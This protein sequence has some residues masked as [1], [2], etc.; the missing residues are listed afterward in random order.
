MKRGRVYGA[1]GARMTGDQVT[2]SLTAKGLAMYAQQLDVS[3]VIAVLTPV[4]RSPSQGPQ[5]WQRI[6][7][8]RR[9]VISVP[10]MR[11][12]VRTCTPLAWWTACM[13]GNHLSLVPNCAGS[14]VASFAA[15]CSCVIVPPPWPGTLLSLIYS[16]PRTLDP[17]NMGFDP[18]AATDGCI[19]CHS[20][21]VAAQPIPRLRRTNHRVVA[22]F[23][24]AGGRPGATG[25]NWI[26]RVDGSIERFG[27][28]HSAW[29]P[30]A[31]LA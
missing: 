6:D 12:S 21:H 1:S 28:T 7:A 14:N 15:I 9:P 17:F 22:P 23:G 5:R 10:T 13:S 20:P 24:L 18:A 3:A 27:A 4:L 25:Q 19:D 31:V 8:M 30:S 11:H 2:P 16:Q 26:E 29:L